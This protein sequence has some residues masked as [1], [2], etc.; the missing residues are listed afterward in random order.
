MTLM[1]ES[2]AIYNSMIRNAVM[3]NVET[4][5]YLLK[6]FADSN[7]LSGLRLIYKRLIFFDMQPDLVFLTILVSSHA[8]V[9]R[10]AEA[11]TYFEESV[12]LGLKL[13]S[14]IFNA[15]LN[16]YGKLRDLHSLQQTFFKMSQHGVE[17]DEA[18]FTIIIDAHMKAGDVRTALLWI[19]STLGMTPPQNV[20]FKP[21]KVAPST[22]HNFSAVINGFSQS[23]EPE[24][25][26]KWF[27][28]MIQNGHKPNEVVYTSLI[29]GYCRT[30]KLA[31]ARTLQK[32]VIDAK[33]SRDV[34]FYNVLI[35]SQAWFG[36]FR[37]AFELV[38]EMKKSGLKPDAI[39]Y[40]ILI[41]GLIKK[42]EFFKAIELYHEMV[43][44]GLQP[45]LHT[46]IALLTHL[47]H[48]GSYGVFEKGKTKKNT[49]NQKE[50][51]SLPRSNPKTTKL[52]LRLQIHDSLLKIYDAY[53]KDVQAT[54]LS[55]VLDIYDAVTAFLLNVNKVESAFTILN[56]AIND[57]CVI[58]T[59]ILVRLAKAVGHRRGWFGMV[60]V[61]DKIKEMAQLR[62]MHL[63]PAEGGDDGLLVGTVPVEEEKKD[64]KF[65]ITVVNF[66]R[67]WGDEIPL[68]VGELLI[69][70]YPFY[71][72]KK[73]WNEYAIC[74]AGASAKVD[75]KMR[76]L[77]HDSKLLRYDRNS[78]RYFIYGG[79][80][81]DNGATMVWKLV[82]KLMK[83][84]PTRLGQ[85]EVVKKSDGQ[86]RP[87]QLV[88]GETFTRFCSIFLRHCE[89]C[90][91]WGSHAAV[92]EWLD[93]Q[94]LF[95]EGRKGA[96]DDYI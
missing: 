49:S 35:H 73:Y 58:D 31:I 26:R 54:N 17:P 23:R 45:T 15:L 3:P 22:L 56:D 29:R 34:R 55:P 39:T 93:D 84:L 86:P 14:F 20:H 12:K 71:G 67:H 81:T 77:L 85:S 95:I 36:H 89:Q 94:C 11:Q 41:D 50:D 2:K 72:F 52:S 79:V 82:L 40:G 83:E 88:Y 51:P 6:G 53:R 70:A 32:D 30:Q 9:G 7:D 18:T 27:D 37:K 28:R 87:L 1:T 25:A 74:H 57:K 42:R 48:Y 63:E 76:E 16:G 78:R 13:D 19:E 24:I 5:T 59:S 65:K 43:A 46:Y 91:L 33:L 75:K 69:A 92:L 8:R 44:G 38:K 21:T 4:L 80:S 60:A 64:E 10:M 90:E 62:L 66:G 47:G 68:M 96:K 61:T